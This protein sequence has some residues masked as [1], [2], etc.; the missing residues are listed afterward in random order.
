M[1]K[2]FGADFSTVRIHADRQSHAA[3]S[4][5]NARA[6]TLGEHIHF[7][8]GEYVPATGDGSRLLA[9]ELSHVLQ[10]RAPASPGMA[11]PASPR[12]S[13][14]E[15]ALEAEADRAASA[16][17]S[18]RPAR[19][20]L[21]AG[22]PATPLRQRGARPQGQGA[23]QPQPG[24][25][26]PVDPSAR[27]L[28]MIDD[29]RRAAAIRA[30]RAGFKAGGIEGA[31]AYLEAKR[32]AQIK[33][34]WPDPNME[35]VAEITGKMGGLLITVAVKVAA[36]GDPE[37][38]TRAGYVRAHQPPIIL[39][40]AFFNDTPEQRI[41]T[42]VHESAHVVGIGSADAA[43]HYYPVFD[44]DSKGDFS[45]ADSWANYVNCLSGQPPDKPITITGSAR[46]APP[47]S[48]RGKKP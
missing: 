34:D 32:L 45:A 4:A 3:A 21:V 16:F 9:H 12:G 20:A 40:P 46:S 28:K 6:F 18:G 5:L 14:T 23:G 7:A 19:I 33:F 41:R 17:A 48:S 24:I 8:A 26:Q 11:K 39:C 1:G 44:C 2:A 10:Q 30:Q 31:Q 27:Q 25:V 15:T 42:M 38:G 29:A 35:Q 13:A 43:E 22:R 36:R 37:C 47:A